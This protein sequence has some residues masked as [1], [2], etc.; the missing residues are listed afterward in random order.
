M[1][2]AGE[3]AALGEVQLLDLFGFLLGSFVFPH[4]KPVLE[5]DAY[6][7]DQPHKQY[8]YQRVKIEHLCCVRDDELRVVITYI[9]LEQREKRQRGYHYDAPFSRQQQTY[10]QI[11]EGEP[12]YRTAV[13]SPAEEERHWQYHKYHGD[14]DYLADNIYSM[15]FQA[16]IGNYR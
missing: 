16:E 4:E 11:R 2:H 1:A 14:G 15:I 7:Y 6:D 8:G 5:H 10:I 12:Y 13:Q 9:V 3:E